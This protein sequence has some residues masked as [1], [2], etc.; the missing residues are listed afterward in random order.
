MKKRRASAAVKVSLLAAVAASV[1]A[2]KEE[3]LRRDAEMLFPDPRACLHEL[4]S[5]N[6]QACYASEA[7]ARLLH[8]SSAPSFNDQAL[9]EKETGVTCQ[10]NPATT[11]LMS[12][13]WIPI[14]TGFLVGREIQRGNGEVV[15]SSLPVYERRDDKREGSS[16]SSGGGS[17]GSGAGGVGARNSLYSG[18]Q[19]VGQTNSGV[20]A[21]QVVPNQTGVRMLSD[22]LER[23]TV[24]RGGLGGSGRQFA[25]SVG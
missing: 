17:G 8:S 25:S 5:A 15:R 14:M 4:G 24:T 2:C 19:I 10:A 16:T 22:A 18:G 23:S 3:G 12:P 7:D 13:L 11:R 20:G 21:R 9:C 6:T 1:T